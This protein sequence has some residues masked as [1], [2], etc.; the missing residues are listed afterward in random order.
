[1][2]MT[3]QT[4]V[5][6]PVDKLHPFV[7]HPYKVKDDEEM[8][9]LIESIQ[10]QGVLTPL[11]VRPLEETSDEYEVVS[12]H[13][14][15]RA[16]EKAGMK[17]VPAFIYALD[18][19]AAAIAVVDS[20]LHRAHILPSEKAF[21]YKLKLDA[22][23]RQGITSGQIGQKWSRDEMAES[24]DDSSRQIQRYIRLTNLILEILEYVDSGKMALTPAV[25]LS[26]LTEKE[27]FDLLETME[28]ED[29]TPSLSQAQQ[30]KRLSQSG[31]L[32]AD[33]IFTM[34]T[35]QKPNQREKLKIPMERIRGFFPK[36]YTAEQIETSIV[37]LCEAQYRKRMRDR[38]AR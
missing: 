11:I 5:S 22:M 34:L 26:Y 2:K 27:Q 20:N 33:R 37:K 23:N 35:E 14:R 9:T 17:E 36:E 16:A 1:M 30:M 7:G 25:E 31:E 13:R 24:T 12:G 3:N 8:N 10:A 15:L 38:D 29:C 28:S 21:A 19:D 4:P 6:I 32:N 18:R